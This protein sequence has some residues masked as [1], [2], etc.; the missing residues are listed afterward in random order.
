MGL[1]RAALGLLEA[2]SAG[3]RRA[4]AR[5]L[6]FI[7]ESDPEELGEALAELGRRSG[8][9][10]WVGITGPPGAGKSS[11]TAALI[12]RLREGGKS[13]AV[14]AVDP[15][16]PLSGGALLGDRVRMQLHATDPGVFIRSM[17]SRGHLGGLASAASVAARALEA[18]GF[19]VV[20]VETVGVGQGEVEVAEVA[21]TTVVVLGP[22]AGDHVQMFKAGLLEVADVFCVNKADLPGAADVAREI[23][24]MLDLGPAR[25][26]R[27]PVL[28]AS[29]LTG[30]G[31]LELWEA[32]SAHRRY[33][34][35]SGEVERRRRS[36]VAREIA[37]LALG[38]LRAF[39]DG[40][41]RG[42]LDSLAERVVRGETDF[43]SAARALARAAFGA[44]S[45]GRR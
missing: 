12:S 28:L 8:R 19:D 40:E 16:S 29:A 7:E 23:E 20:L 41:F 39:L 44:E 43:A 2:A 25:G 17:A 14:L 13:V 4:L 26:W 31:I 27:P 21:E 34:E 18:A 6:T 3:D 45:G 9:K 24:Q 15:T 5:L 11:L 30:Q 36:R 35:E 37:E 22:G 33:L 1:G 10:G 32:V 38:R 42:E